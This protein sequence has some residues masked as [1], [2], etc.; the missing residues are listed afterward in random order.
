MTSLYLFNDVQEVIKIIPQ[1]NLLEV[2][3][4]EELQDSGLPIDRLTASFLAKEYVDCDY[5]AVKDPYDENS[6][7]MYYVNQPI[8]END[9]VTLE[10]IQLGYYELKYAVNRDMRPTSQDAKYMYQQALDSTGWRVGYVDESSQLSTNFYYQSALSSVEQ[11]AN[12]F[13]QEI[14]FKVEISGNAI[15]DKWLESYDRRGAS[16]KKRFTHGSNALSVVKSVDRSE[17]YT[18]LIGRGRGENLENDAYG[19]RIN[20]TDVEWKKSAGKPVDKPKGQDFVEL[21]EKTQD[22]GVYANGA[23]KAKLGVVVFEDIEEPEKLLQATYDELLNRARQL[24][25]YKSTV[26]DL[27]NAEL[28]ETVTIHRYDLGF[29][30]E[31]RIFKIERNY[32]NL[33]LSQI[34][35]GDV[36]I[37]SRVTRQK[38]VN[39]QIGELSDKQEQTR[40]D[41]TRAIATADGKNT[42]YFGNEEPAQKRVGDQWRRDNPQYPGFKQVLI[43]NG[44]TWEILIDEWNNHEIET[45]ISDNEQ[46]T[47]EAMTQANKGVSI[48]EQSRIDVVLAGQTADQALSTAND[49]IGQLPA[50]KSDVSGL[51]TSLTNEVL[52]NLKTTVDGQQVYLKTVVDQ[53]HASLKTTMANVDGNTAA[54]NSVK[55]T[56]E[57]NTSLIASLRTDVDNKATIQQYNSL[58]STVDGNVTTI[59][60]LRDGKADKLTVT[61][62]ANQWNVKVQSIQTELGNKVEN[63]K[64]VSSNSGNSNSGNW[65]K[66]LTT[67]IDYQYGRVAG[68]IE[69][70]EDSNGLEGNYYAKVYYNHKLKDS[71]GSR[72]IVEFSLTDARY[73]SSDL[74]KA[75]ISI[76]NNTVDWYMKIPGTYQR[77]TFNP[78]MEVGDAYARTYLSNQGFVKDLPSGTQINAIE[79]GNLAQLSVLSDQIN[80]RV[81][82]GEIIR[83]LNLSTEGLLIDAGKVQITGDTYIQNSVIKNAMIGD[84]QINTAKIADLA[85]TSAKIVSLDVSKLSAGIINTNLIKMRASASG[86]SIEMDGAGISGWD[87]NGKLRMKWGIQDLA[88]DGQ[89]SPANLLFYTGNGTKS[90]SAGTNVDDLFVLGTESS[91]VDGLLRFPRKLTIQSTDLYLTPQNL[92]TK[93]WHIRKTYDGSEQPMMYA[94]TPNTGIL[95][96]SSYYLKDV[97]TYNGYIRKLNVGFGSGAPQ[98]GDLTV[99]KDGRGA[100]V[101]SHAVYNRT[102][103]SQP[104]VCITDIGTFGRLT[105]ASKY[106]LDITPVTDEISLANKVLSLKPKKWFDKGIVEAYADTLT[107]GKSD[108][109]DE[110]LP[111]SRAY[112]LIAEDLEEAGLD[113]YCT[114]NSKGEVEGI[115]YDRLWTVLIPIIKE[116]QSRI[117]KLEK[118]L[119]VA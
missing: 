56:A 38:T 99:D 117:D 13:N 68:S 111:I 37:E 105:S 16:S 85:V 79:T 107:T 52:P 109:S 75:V 20:F 100:Y 58:K 92:T 5:M 12:L 26:A 50:I 39:K 71:V 53:D 36:L 15:T 95:G 54:L 7:H 21:P 27:G 78:T 44:E 49:A 61:E 114:Y 62:M 93:P 116:Q 88:G 96:H 34:A 86:K 70:L 84:G 66:F 18:A 57:G 40:V 45:A 3:Q 42:I 14:I 89:S 98:E 113:M 102:Y 51:Q 77:Y 41:V 97:F 101:K 87:A 33:K 119:G 80:L 81:K 55:S 30:Y 25:Q 115:Q 47:Q 73:L 103:A 90:V 108:I 48:A 106:K 91:T 10:G 43:W 82:S 60:D 29:H 17:I 1:K 63:K 8:I 11:I 9:I 59:A 65:T 6:F 22:L 19:R 118:L 112:G 94:D 32:L 31:T 2:T 46:A 69:I 64:Y 4:L 28:G 83:Q 110:H 76:D 24:V 72:P 35:L 74:F 67:T 23:K 104:Q